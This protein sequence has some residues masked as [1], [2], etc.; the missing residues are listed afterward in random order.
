MMLRPRTVALCA[1]AA[2]GLLL[3]ACGGDGTGA[4][5]PIE[6]GGRATL[7]PVTPTGSAAVKW[8]I[9]PISAT[10][11][12]ACYCTT[13]DVGI[14]TLRYVTSTWRVT[15]T[16]SL[17]VVPGDA[18]LGDPGTLGSMAAIDGGCTNA[19]KGVSSPVVDQVDLHA[20]NTGG[21]GGDSFTWVHPDPHVIEPYACNHGAQGPHGH[22]GIIKVV[23]A[24]G[25]QQ[26][27]ASYFG[28]HTGMSTD[29][30]P[31]G[32]QQPG[33]PTCVGT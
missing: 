24:H 20:T 5:P 6:A 28:T 23:V 10:F 33:A 27:V 30:Q 25:A 31:S 11:D 19:G 7:A 9:S 1:G 4:T 22:E 3:A 17:V 32:H 14:T 21:D 16:I 26:C 8:S 15:W 18:G 13:Y 29:T 2:C 12:Q